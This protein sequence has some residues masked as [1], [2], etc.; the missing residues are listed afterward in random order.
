M[1]TSFLP[2]LF[3]FFNNFYDFFFHQ[4]SWVLAL[5]PPAIF[6]FKAATSVFLHCGSFYHDSLEKKFGYAARSFALHPISFLSRCLGSL[7]AFSGAITVTK[8]M[9][10]IMEDLRKMGKVRAMTSFVSSCFI[11]PTT[12]LPLHCTF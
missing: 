7:A 8:I 6:G 11:I 12:V 9:K 1:I 3:S 5:S 4:S 2:T 10:L